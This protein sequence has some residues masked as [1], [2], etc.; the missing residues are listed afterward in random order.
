MLGGTGKAL[1][2]LPDRRGAQQDQLKPSGAHQKF[3][4]D[5]SAAYRLRVV[6]FEFRARPSV[7]PRLAHEAQKAIPSANNASLDLVG[8]LPVSV[9]L[10][11][12]GDDM[13]AARAVALVLFQQ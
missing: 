5:V 7:H 4:T 12:S 1:A 8:H 2:G 9:G 10:I 11:N 3:P 6:L 13:N